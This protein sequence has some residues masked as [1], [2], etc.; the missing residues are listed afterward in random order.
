MI[1]ASRNLEKAK[2]AVAEIEA[3][4]VKGSLS[5]VQLDVTDEKSI[6]DA[7]A[8]VEQQF[9]RLDVLVNNA[10]V[11]ALK[12]GLKAAYQ[13][14]LETNVLGPVLVAEAF[15]PLL[16]KSKDVYSIYISSGER[17]LTRNA[18]QKVATYANFPSGSV[19]A[20]QVSKSA[21]NMVALTEY[22][23][24]GAQGLKVFVVSPGFVRSNLRGTSEE[25]ISGW[26]G[27]GDPAVS[28]GI[29][30]DIVQGNQDE[31]V[32]GYIH[33]DGVYAW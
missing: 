7:A 11:G 21:M 2:A 17:T 5:T 25:E 15:R 20:Y 32:G 29:I 22:R 23:D 3:A 31:H 4:G 14:C 19:G 16:F 12:L 9:G 24:Y 13:L 8:H 18:S 26:G 6:K 1:I 28:G 27:A 10:G 33:K 30:L